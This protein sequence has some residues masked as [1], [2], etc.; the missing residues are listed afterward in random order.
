MGDVSSLD[1]GAIVLRRPHF[2]REG[3]ALYFMLSRRPS[4]ALAGIEP[5]VWEAIG[6]PLTMGV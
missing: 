5:E 6:Q 2:R 4:R 3:A 1:S